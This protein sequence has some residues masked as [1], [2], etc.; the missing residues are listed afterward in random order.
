LES[1]ALLYGDFGMNSYSADN[2]EAMKR[3]DNALDASSLQFSV[4]FKN[5]LLL[6]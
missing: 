2:D 3:G 6:L 1:L 4:E 5:S